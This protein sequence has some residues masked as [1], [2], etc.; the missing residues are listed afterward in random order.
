MY[1]FHVFAI[2][3]RSDEIVYSAELVGRNRDAIK[4]I[5]LADI[6]RENEVTNEDI[7]NYHFI[8]QQIGEGYSK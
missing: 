4:M 6:V 7:D 2:D 1:V 3:K 5:A 8:V